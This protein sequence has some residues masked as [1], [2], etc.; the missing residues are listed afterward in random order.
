MVPPAGY[1]GM[2][3]DALVRWNDCSI[4]SNENQEVSFQGSYSSYSL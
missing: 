3:H 2:A 4:H 1:R